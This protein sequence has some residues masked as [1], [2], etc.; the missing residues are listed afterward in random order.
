M[1]ARVAASRS[2]KTT[3]S[4]RDVALLRVIYTNEDSLQNKIEELRSHIAD[5][6][7]N[8]GRHVTKDAELAVMR[9]RLFRKDH[10]DCKKGR[11]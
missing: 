5:F 9:Y 11:G 1:P 8:G 6:S 10:I 4:L 3:K 7:P 2:M